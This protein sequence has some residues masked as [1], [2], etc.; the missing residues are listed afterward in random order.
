[1]PARPDE[2]PLLERVLER[3]D[4]AAH[5]RLREPQLLGRTGDAAFAGNGPEVE[6]VVIVEPFHVGSRV[7]GDAQS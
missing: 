1:V 4:L 5:R 2:Q 6:E 7:L 3:P